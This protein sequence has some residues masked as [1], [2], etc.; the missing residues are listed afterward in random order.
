MLRILCRRRIASFEVSHCNT[1]MESAPLS[2]SEI[3]LKIVASRCSN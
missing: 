3:K 2:G 1:A